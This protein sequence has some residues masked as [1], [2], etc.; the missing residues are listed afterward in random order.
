MRFLRRHPAVSV[1]AAVLIT[2]LVTVLI[3]NLSSGEKK[4][5]HRIETLYAVGDPQFRRSMGS[6]LGPPLLPGNR[7]VP[8]RNGTE[9]F[10][11]MLEAIGGARQTITFETFIYWSGDIGRRFA[12]ALAERAEAGVAVHV[13]LDWVGSTRM[14]EPLLERMEAAGVVV[15]RYHPPRWYTLS[16]MNNR[17]HRKLLIV[18]GEVGFTGG[19]GIADPW[20]G[21]AQDPDHWRDS[22]FRVDGPVVAQMQAAFLDNWMK[23]TGDVLHGEPY[24]PP[25][26]PQGEVTAQMF[27]SDPGEGSESVRLMYLLSIASAQRSVYISA[28]YFVPDNLSVSTIVA[29]RERGVHVE[30][31]VPGP[32]IDTETT[33][34]ASRAR[35]G[36]LLE[37]GVIIHEYQPTMY[38]C[39]VMVVDEQWSTVG[40]TNF[41]NRSF[42]LNDEANLNVLD[43]DFAAALLKDFAD[44]RRHARRVTLEAWRNRPW[45]EKLV[46]H[47][48]ALLRSQL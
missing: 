1:L 3:L 12:D 16:K 33:R 21:D 2:A 44:D 13:L 38:H 14:E 37:A 22:H 10:P 20:L 36:P 47:T 43:R 24:F 28:A 9:I 5:S 27:R 26:S 25:L 42:R 48:A 35:W 8:L 30:V 6:L 31:I 23:A 18:D 32:L 11:A 41:D 15:R 46:E 39:K 40:S 4:I 17:T 29:A 45:R 19:V 7:V 34:R